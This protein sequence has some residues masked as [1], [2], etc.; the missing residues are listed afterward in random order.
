LTEA[1]GTSEDLNDVV[2][3][4]LL[5]HLAIVS[6]EAAKPVEARKMGPLRTSIEAVK[7]GI[8]LGTQL[9]TLWEGVQKTLSAAGIID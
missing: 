9:S 3:K 1:V 4:E 2:R 8:T 6:E 7:S 5:E